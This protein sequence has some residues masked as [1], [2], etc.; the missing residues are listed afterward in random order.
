ML[1]TLGG[2]GIWT[3]IDFIIAATGKL[4]DGQGKLINKPANVGL[5]VGLIIGISVVGLVIISIFAAITIPQYQKYV[6]SAKEVV[7]LTVLTDIRS[8]ED[9]YYI[10]NITYT[11]SYEELAKKTTLTKDSNINYGPIYI[12]NDGNS[13]SFSISH[14]DSSTLYIYDS[15]Y[16]NIHPITTKKNEGLTSSSW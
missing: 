8:S 2:L 15:A 5:V 13:Y 6:D 9:K 12:T 10:D 7:A 14:K 3:L 11:D 16:D 1:L 4:R